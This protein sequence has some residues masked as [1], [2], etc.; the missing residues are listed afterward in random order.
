[1]SWIGSEAEFSPRNIQTRE[2]R[3]E[4]VFRVRALAAN[5]DGLLKRGL[6]VEV[7]KAK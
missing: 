4:L 1:V 6:P 7:W 5:K 2:S 3:N